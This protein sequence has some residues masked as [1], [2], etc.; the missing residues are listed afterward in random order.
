MI[1]RKKVLEYYT[2]TEGN[3][4]RKLSIKLIKDI[5]DSIGSCKKC[6]YWDKKGTCTLLKIEMSKSDY[7]S[8]FK[9]LSSS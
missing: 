9:S 3:V 1:K 2:K 6:H 7:C 8:K 4:T 5:Y